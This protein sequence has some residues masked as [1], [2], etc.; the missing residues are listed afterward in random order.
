MN[1]NQSS[2][3]AHAQSRTRGNGKDDQPPAFDF[4]NLPNPMLGFAHMQ[5]M[6]LRMMLRQQ[7]DMLGFLRRRCEQDLRLVDTIAAAREPRAMIKAVTDFYSTAARDY[8]GGIGSAADEAPR[9]AVAARDATVDVVRSL[10]ER[11]DRAHRA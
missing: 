4:A 8:A 11:A 9:A 5:A 10:V 2:T 6:G 3:Q 7:H 1:P